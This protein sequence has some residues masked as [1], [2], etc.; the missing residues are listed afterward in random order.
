MRFCRAVDLIGDAAALVARSLVLIACLISAANATS[1]YL[2]NLSSNGWLEI[3]WYMFAAIVFLGASQTLRI[4][5]HVRVDLIYSCISDRTR[6]W[7]DIIGICLFLLPAMAY[8]TYLAWP[9]FWSSFATLEKSNNAGGLLLWPAKA[10]LP[11]G[12]ALVFLQGSAELLKRVFAMLGFL[13]LDMG[14][15]APLQ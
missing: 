1:R 10:A 14:Y 3:Q 11:L 2:F 12:F 13:T 9:F 15:E 4:N 7:V 6:V 8:L 5:G